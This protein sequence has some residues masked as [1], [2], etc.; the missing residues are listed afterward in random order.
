MRIS[1]TNETGR[2]CVILAAED[3][4][5]DVLFIREALKERRY[6]GDVRFVKD[7]EELMDYLHRRGGYAGPGLAPRP[8]LILLDLRMPKKDGLE[9]LREIR[10]DVRLRSI[11]VV[12]LTTSQSERDIQSSY[13]LGASSYIIKPNEFEALVE[14]MGALL[15]LHKLNPVDQPVFQPTSPLPRGHRVIR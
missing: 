5:D 8:D 4:D 13:A 15:K 2:R 3:D 6:A 10:A 12:V 14:A 11:P 1:K 9:A 7:G